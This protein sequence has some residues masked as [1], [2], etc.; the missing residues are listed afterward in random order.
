MV[1][2][3]QAFARHKDSIRIS[4][5]S[6]EDYPVSLIYTRR[7]GESDDGIA[8][9]DGADNRLEVEVIARADTNVIGAETTDEFVCLESRIVVWP[10]LIEE[11]LQRRTWVE[12]VKDHGP[13][14]KATGV[15]FNLPVSR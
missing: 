11:L 8:L 1:D 12:G 13:G 5:V 15:R 4:T 3:R 9:V 14:H 10:A 7:P 6:V 2:Q